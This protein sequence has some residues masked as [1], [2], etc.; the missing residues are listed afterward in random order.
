[1]ENVVIIGSGPAGYTAAI[2]C[3]RADLKPVVIAGQLPGGQ[4]VQ[5]TDIE[6]YPGF[7]DA[8]GGVD[9]MMNFQKQAERFGTEVIYD[10]V[11]SAD[12]KDK[13]PHKVKLGNGNEIESRAVIIATGASPK[14]LGLEDEKRLQSKGVSSCA[15]CDGAFYRDVP[16]V[17]VGGGDSAMEEA[18]FLTKFASKVYVIHRRDKLRASK[19]MADRALNNKKIEFVWNSVVTAISGKDEVESV[20]VKNVKTEEEDEISCKAYFAALG[21]IPATEK[22]KNINKDEKGYILL[23]KATSETNLEGVFAAGDCVD[24]VY[25]QAVT[26]AGMGCRAALDVE[27]WLEANF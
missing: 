24:G 1:M 13:G 7:P 23:E 19:I 18:G 10:S 20:T 5:T 27:K 14:W 15:T 4:L 12:F 16:V 3:A 22:F 25:Q 17:V 6:N 11:E 2:Y 26:A 8:V 21:H 9:L